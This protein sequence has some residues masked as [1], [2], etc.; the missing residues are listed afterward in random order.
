MPLLP[1]VISTGRLSALIAFAALPW[2]VHLVRTAAGIGTA[3]PNAAAADLADGVIALGARERI[4]RIAVAGIAVAI[5]VAM[6]PPVLLLVA[7]VTIVLALSSLLVG[8][9]WRTSVLVARRRRR[10]DGD[11]LVAQPAGGDTWSWSRPHRRARS[12]GRPG[13]AS[14]D[15]ASMNIGQARLGPARPGAL[16]PGGHRACCCRG[17][18]A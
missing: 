13:A 18:G 3:D 14:T 7:A 15:V 10:G 5:A 2:F 4:R 16:R 11:R 8:A 17:H 6:A 1:G 9:G 12:P